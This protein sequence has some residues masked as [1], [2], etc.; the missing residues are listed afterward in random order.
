MK[1]AKS[2]LTKEQANQRNLVEVEEDKMP[3][4]V[5]TE[6]LCAPGIRQ[7][8]RERKVFFHAREV[9]WVANIPK[10]PLAAKMAARA[11]GATISQI[12]RWAIRADKKRR[13]L[14][15]RYEAIQRVPENNNPVILRLLA[16]MNLHAAALDAFRDALDD[17]IEERQW[18]THGGDQGV[19]ANPLTGRAMTWVVGGMSKGCIPR[20]RN[21]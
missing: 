10:K 12:G 2:R 4:Q 17:A 1:N 5:A 11:A 20:W 16:A 15:R 6:M 18:R 14:Q 21:A 7:T 3:E 8:N 13:G 19:T 9:N